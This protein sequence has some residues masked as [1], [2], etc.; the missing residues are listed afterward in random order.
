MPGRHLNALLNAE[1]A[2]G[3]ALDEAAV[4]NHRRATFL[5][6]G[7]Q[8]PLP[9]NRLEP[10]AQPTGFCPHNLRE[11]LHALYALVAFRDDAKAREMAERCIESVRTLWRP[12]AGWDV[13]RLES[14]GLSYQPCQGFI[15]GEGR[16]LGPLVKYFRA[17][18]YGPALEL[19]LVMKEKAVAQGFPEDGTF[20]PDRMGTSHVHS[21]TCV[22]SS[23]A[24]L[25]DLLG[26]AALLAQVKAMYDNGLWEMRDQIGWSPESL[27][28]EDSD[29]GESNNSGDILE[30]ALI[31]GKWGYPECYHDAERMLRC[32]LLPSQVRDVSFIEDPPHPDGVDGLRAVADR[33][34]GAY[35]FPAPYGHR[36]AG[37]GRRNL[38][39]NMDIVGGTVGSLCEAHRHVAMSG[40]GGTSI[41][42]LFDLETEMV[43][44]QSP[45]THDCL[46]VIPKCTGP[47]AVRIP[48]WVDRET[49]D[50]VGVDTE[51]VPAVTTSPGG[52]GYLFFGNAPA[53]QPIELRF[54]LAGNEVTLSEKLHT[55]AIR[56]RLR[57][58][59]V[60][61]M[62]NLGAEL[63]FFDPIF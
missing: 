2:V 14:L 19:A 11:G 35:G 52:N 40:P 23:L 58:D 21:I 18:G 59:A 57:G 55:R 61:A 37:K 48:P 1:D 15:H 10:N 47:L 16:M 42:M 25:A 9:L 56:V 60:V 32:H 7:G 4:E 33:H 28:Q 12:D 26:D 62:D 22:T 53:G 63:T 50:V 17:T 43:Q 46:R 29:H 44:V 20:N 45:Y 31:L 5:S 49:L 3:A 30:T 24:Q 41:N 8:V 54:T 27:D 36:S 51:P 34:L 6:Y 38:S 13:A 39:F